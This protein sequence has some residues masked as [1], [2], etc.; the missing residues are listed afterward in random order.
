MSYIDE[1]LIAGEVVLHRSRI[2]G[3][4]LLP[5][6]LLGLLL[7]VVVVGLYFLISAWVESRTTEIAITN[8]RVIAKSGFIRRETIEINLAKVEALRVDQGLWGRMLNFGT[9]VITGAGGAVAPMRNIADPLAFRR[10]FME[11][12]DRKD[13]AAA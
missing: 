6:I 10:K 8:K 12:T 3:W 2:S 4:V 5:R 1:S 7:L 13:G 9:L 11:A